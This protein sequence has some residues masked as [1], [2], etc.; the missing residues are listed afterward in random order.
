MSIVG[1]SLKMIEQ[2]DVEGGAEGVGKG[3]RV[4]PVIG[5]EEIR[6]AEG[7]SKDKGFDA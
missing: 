1:G 2:L 4:V 6:A 7:E 5:G 3:A